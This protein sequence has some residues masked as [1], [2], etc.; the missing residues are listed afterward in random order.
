MSEKEEALKTGGNVLSTI[1]TS[2]AFRDFFSYVI[3]G[4]MLLLSISL[5]I[6]SVPGNWN[7]EFAL[8]NWM[9]YLIISIPILGVSYVIGFLIQSLGIR[10]KVISFTPGS[11]DLIAHYMIHQ[12]LY[13]YADVR[14]K[15][16]FERAGSL[17]QMCGNTFVLTILLFFL[18]TIKYLVECR[19]EYVFLLI[20]VL[21]IMLI[22][23]IE[24]KKQ[25]ESEVN[26]ALTSLVEHLD[27]PG[28]KDILEYENIRIYIKNKKNK[29]LHKSMN[30]YWKNKYYVTY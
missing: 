29:N 15:Y 8:D 19:T 23:F 7:T 5:C 2:F 22:S 18:F 20:C 16:I 26:W 27:E 14:R 9:F 21:L 28:V 6:I 30:Y 10:T 24:H 1:Y 3:P 25:R 17:K 12:C 13:K 4:F 11:I